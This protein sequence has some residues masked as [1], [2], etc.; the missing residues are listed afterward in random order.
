MSPQIPL[1]ESKMAPMVAVFGD[2]RVNTLF[3]SELRRL[4]TSGYHV[5]VYSLPGARFESICIAA[6]NYIRCNN[7][8]ITYI[9][10]GINDMTTPHKPYYKGGRTTYTFDWSSE[11]DFVYTMCDTI[12]AM[13]KHLLYLHGDQ[14]I[15]LCP[16]IG[17]QLNRTC[18]NA[19]EVRQQYMNNGICIN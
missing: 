2:S 12:T 16:I 11:D 18:T 7:G 1:F 14:R 3:E 9:M 6:H 13:Y 5:N 10:G 15:I 17:S 8:D 4:D 19:T